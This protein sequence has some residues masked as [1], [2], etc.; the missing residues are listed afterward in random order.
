MSVTVTAR[1]YVTVGEEYEAIFV[2][3]E[4]VPHVLEGPGPD[5]EGRGVGG[6]GGERPPPPPPRP[7]VTLVAELVGDDVEV[8]LTAGEEEG[9]AGSG[10]GAV[11]CLIPPRFCGVDIVSGGGGIHVDA[12]TES[13]VALDSGGGHVTL[14]KIRGAILRIATS[15]RVVQV[16]SIKIC[17]E[18][19]YAFS[20]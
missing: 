19:A 4:W 14:G 20:S 16:D 6:R 15:G 11:R 17:V 18:S 7:A 5:V 13:H 8:R 12:V 9:G 3:A 2:E 10:R 1:P